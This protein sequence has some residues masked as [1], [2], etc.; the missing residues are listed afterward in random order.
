MSS[1]VLTTCPYCGSGCTFHLNVSNGEIVSV[2]PNNQNAVN[3]GIL[4]LKGHFGYDFVHHRERLTQPLVRKDGKLIE[5][6]WD[7]AISLIAAKLGKIKE[8]YGA[9][10]IAAFSSARCTNEENYLMQKLMRAV[11]GTNNIDHCARL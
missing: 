6:T 4:C 11:I 5:A 7:E 8:E 10:S 1:S 2:T 9:D 3:E